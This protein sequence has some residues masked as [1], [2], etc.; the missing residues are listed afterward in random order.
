MADKRPARRVYSITPFGNVLLTRLLEDP[1]S[2]S[3]P[4][5]YAEFYVRLTFF[6]LVP[7][8]TRLRILRARQRALLNLVPQ[9][10]NPSDHKEDES[11]PYARKLAAFS[12]ER[13]HAEIEWVE[14]LIAEERAQQAQGE[15]AG[16]QDAG[17]T[18]P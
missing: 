12:L 3:R 14:E 15:A 2:E 4:N 16:R 6:H 8:E 18:P 1:E 9:M 10:E 17:A 7:P 13:H 11:R 5:P